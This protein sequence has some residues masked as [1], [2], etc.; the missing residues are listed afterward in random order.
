MSPCNDLVLQYQVEKKY[1][2]TFYII[3]YIAVKMVL[4]SVV[5][6]L[7]RRQLITFTPLRQYLLLWNITLHCAYIVHKTNGC[8][9]E[10]IVL[11]NQMLFVTLK[12]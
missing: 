6:L 5:R 3:H 1:C 10:Q 8:C 9:E 12:G 11:L 7:E 2:Q 4:M